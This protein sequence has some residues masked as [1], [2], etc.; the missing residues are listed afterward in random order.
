MNI[1]KNGTN[2]T[3]GGTTAVMLRECA[4][5]KHMFVTATYFMGYHTIA[6][7]SSDFIGCLRMANE[8]T[9][10]ISKHT[11]AEVFPYSVFYVFY[12]QYLTIVH[13]T[14]F[15]LGKLSYVIAIT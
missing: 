5:F 4:A 12:E 7:T 15:N 13:D 1:I 8:I 14:I 2:S 11:E 10:N 3:V 6:R 9:A